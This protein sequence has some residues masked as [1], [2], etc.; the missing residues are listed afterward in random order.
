MVLFN[1]KIALI[2]T[3]FEAWCGI[4]AKRIHSAAKLAV[5]APVTSAGEGLAITLQGEELP[6]A[7]VQ[8]LRAR[9]RRLVWLV[10]EAML[11]T[12]QAFPKPA[13]STSVKPEGHPS[14]E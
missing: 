12:H 6:V 5:S 7:W 4:G 14:K 3:R 8:Q 13:W 9:W 11:K 2:R 10:R 1:G